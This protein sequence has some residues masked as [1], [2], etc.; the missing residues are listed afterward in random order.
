VGGSTESSRWKKQSR[1]NEIVGNITRNKSVGAWTAV[2]GFVGL[3]FMGLMFS[4]VGTD[5]TAVTNVPPKVYVYDFEWVQADSLRY[6]TCQLSSDLG[7]SPLT[8]MVGK[9]NIFYSL[10]W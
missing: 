8:K 2:L 7:D 9:F 1:F 10:L 4:A 3:A 6:P 5:S